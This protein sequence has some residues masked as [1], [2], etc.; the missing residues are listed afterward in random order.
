MLRMRDVTGRAHEFFLRAG[1]SFALRFT[2]ILLQFI[3]AIVVARILGAEQYGAFT[4]A[5]VIATLLG[6]G[7]SLGLSELAVRELPTFLARGDSRVLRIYIA[8]LVMTLIG[9]AALVGAV[10]AALEQIGILNLEPGW[11]LVSIMVLLHGAVLAFSGVLNSFNRLLASQFLETIVRQLLYLFL[12]AGLVLLGF[13][14]TPAL[15]F[16]IAILA[17][18]P[19]LLA[20]AWLTRVEFRK[21]PVGPLTEAPSRLLWF[22]AALPLFLTKIVNLALLDMDVLMIGF[23]LGD[24]DVGLYRAAARG[25]MLVSMANM[26]ALQL[27]GPMLSR[28]IAEGRDADVQRY[29]DQAAVTSLAL[30]GSICLG[31]GLAGPFYLSLFGSEFAGAVTS[32]RILLVCQ[33]FIVIAGADAV[34]LVMLRRERTVLFIT[35]SALVANLLLNLL[36]IPIWGMEGAAVA[37]LIAMAIV[38]V[39]LVLL[40]RRT[41]RYDTTAIPA[42]LARFTRRTR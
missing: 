6:V 27:V 31:L 16:E 21:L 24:Y 42:I 25:A 39:S 38:R 30:G 8:T 15:L 41:T 36:L 19:V 3:G 26:I 32:L 4:F 10:L 22:G 9:A 20:M 5:F 29:L 37:S 13:S 17:V 11:E 12:I 23:M 40:I 2:G 35:A 34:L 14:V 7:L 28:A 33:L 1:A 18:L